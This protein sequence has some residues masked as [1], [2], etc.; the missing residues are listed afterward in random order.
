MKRMIVV[1]NLCSKNYTLNRPTEVVKRKFKIVRIA[2]LIKIKG[3]ELVYE[4]DY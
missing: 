1:S 3:K 2:L 4:L